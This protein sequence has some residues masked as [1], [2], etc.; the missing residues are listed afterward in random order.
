MAVTRQWKATAT[1]VPYRG[2]DRGHV[3]GGEQ[4]GQRGDVELILGLRDGQTLLGHSIREVRA[5]SDARCVEAATTA[6]SHGQRWS[7]RSLG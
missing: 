1:A 6:G 5:A 4:A 3:I 2:G 7:R